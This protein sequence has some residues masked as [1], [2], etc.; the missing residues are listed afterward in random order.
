MDCGRVVPKG[1]LVENPLS[2]K[3]CRDFTNIIDEPALITYL[4]LKQAHGF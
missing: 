1:A 4:F 3:F 2:E